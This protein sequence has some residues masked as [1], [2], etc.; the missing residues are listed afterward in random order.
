MK[1][2]AQ[3]M[4]NGELYRYAWVAV[5][6]AIENAEKWEKPD[7]KEIA[8]LKAQEEELNKLM[9]SSFVDGLGKEE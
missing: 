3:T 8:R 7:A 4:T 5:K 9:K 2:L 6:K 1:N